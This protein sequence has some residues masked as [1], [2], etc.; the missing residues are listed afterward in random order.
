[1]YVRSDPPFLDFIEY[2]HRN[3]GI[4]NRVISKSWIPVSTNEYNI[5]CKFSMVTWLLLE[6]GVN[7]VIVEHFLEAIIFRIHSYRYYISKAPSHANGAMNEIPFWYGAIA[8]TNH[9]SSEY[10]IIKSNI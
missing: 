10:C 1:M 8:M 3:P 9:A 5:S 4:R 2:Y 7:I 6:N